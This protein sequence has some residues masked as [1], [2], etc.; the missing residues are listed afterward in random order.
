MMSS[1]KNKRGIRM[2]FKEFIKPSL[3]KIIIAV[4]L[5]FIPAYPIIP[6]FNNVFIV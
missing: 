2:N 3:I 5:L 1:I 6:P 4:I